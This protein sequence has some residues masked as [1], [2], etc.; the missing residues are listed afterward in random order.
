MQPFVLALLSL[1]LP[2]AHAADCD[3]RTLAKALDEAPPIRVATAYTELAAC[4]AGRA[5]KA[6]KATVARIKDG[7]DTA[8]A[9]LTAARLGAMTAVRAWVA[10]AEP[11][12]R[13]RT[14]DAMGEVCADD[15]ETATAF[16]VT[17][18]AELGDRFWE[19]RWYRG[20]GACRTDGIRTLLTA[21][22][23][24]PKVGREARPRTPL[25]SLLETY[26]R[27]AGVDAL[28]TLDALL[29][30]P[31][32]DR[33]A[34]DLINPYADAAA[35]AEEAG[36]DGGT[37]AVVASLVAAAPTLPREALERARGVLTSLGATTE[38]EAL[39]AHAFPEAK[40]DTGHPY[41]VAITEV[42][43]C[44]NGKVFAGL[45]VGDVVDPGLRWPD[46]VAD[47]IGPAA[48]SGWDALQG[49]RCG[50]EPVVTVSHSGVPVDAE[51]ATAFR[52]EQQ[53][54]FETT[55]SAA[56]KTWIEDGFS[57]SLP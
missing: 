3:G 15:P 18:A 23:D 38:A 53:A 42:V 11:D 48:T 28:P 8:P 50:A 40:R 20:L 49:G 26:A 4:D 47:Q 21:A 22:L 1:S 41:A 34:V 29:A 35:G 36:V 56:K 51:G 16:F 46:V 31:V 54:A 37:E 24:H 32:D 44:K 7:A 30:E 17:T 43:T 39:A 5:K 19:Q 2:S 9:L 25:Y 33:D 14:L 6:A 27:N 55:H 57:T 13:S 10:D 45:Y 52:A 12:V